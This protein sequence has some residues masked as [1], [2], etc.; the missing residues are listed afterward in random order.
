MPP[1]TSSTVVAATNDLLG[2]AG[3]PVEADL[4]AEFGGLSPD[5]G[6]CAALDV[7]FDL[8]WAPSD[9]SDAGRVALQEAMLDEGNVL[10]EVDDGPFGEAWHLLIV[11]LVAV[12]NGQEPKVPL[13]SELYEEMNALA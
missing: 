1:P 3:A 5:I 2:P 6:V 4:V 12:E 9:G 10:L 13:T 8:Y 11:D 7:L